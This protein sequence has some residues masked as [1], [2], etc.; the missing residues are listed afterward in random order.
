MGRSQTH[1]S[2]KRIPSQKALVRPTCATA[3]GSR[4]SSVLFSLHSASSACPPRSGSPSM[5]QVPS[6]PRRY[7]WLIASVSAV[8]LAGAALA[9]VWAVHHHAPPAAGGGDPV[10]PVGPLYF[11]DVT[12]DSGVVHTYRNGE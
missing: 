11:R 3:A 7:G 10:A 12:A 8:L 5:Q 9:V 2:N 1:A 6:A 4:S